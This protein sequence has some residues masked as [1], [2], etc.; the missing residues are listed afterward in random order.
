ML[1]KCIQDIL[2]RSR[3][4]LFRILVHC[5]LAKVTDTLIDDSSRC[6]TDLTIC[7]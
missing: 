5:G 1:H 3:T 4:T 6:M 2:S 7:A